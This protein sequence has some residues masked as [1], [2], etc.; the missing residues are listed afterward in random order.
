VIRQPFLGDLVGES[1]LLFS[2]DDNADLAVLFG[3]ATRG[4]DIDEQLI[5]ATNVLNSSF[6]G[7]IASQLGQRCLPKRPTRLRVDIARDGLPLTASAI[8]DALAVS[9]KLEFE[10]RAMRAHQLLIFSGASCSRLDEAL[11]QLLTPSER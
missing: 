5:E 8:A 1:L 9:A 7:S 11:E 2:V 10:K 4:I 3:D 6:L